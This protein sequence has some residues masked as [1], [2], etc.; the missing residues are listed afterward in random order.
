MALKDPIKPMQF[1]SLGVK[2]LL[3][4]KLHPQVP[5]FFG[6]GKLDALFRKA[7]EVEANP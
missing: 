7:R 6:A 1:T 2:L 3:K 5:R 4:G